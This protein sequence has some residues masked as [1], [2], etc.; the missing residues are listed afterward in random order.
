MHQR[1]QKLAIATVLAS[2]MAV[3]YWAWS[4]QAPTVATGKRDASLAVATPPGAIGATDAMA[5]ATT[6]AVVASAGDEKPVRRLSTDARR[7]GELGTAYAGRRDALVAYQAF[8]TRARLS[9]PQSEAMLAILLDAQLQ[10]DE[11]RKA[12]RERLTDPAYDEEKE[13]KDRV[14]SGMTKAIFDDVMGRARQVLTDEQLA[15]F[16][17]EFDA[18][19]IVAAATSLVEPAPVP[20]AG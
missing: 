14:P 7:P 19:I 20:Q 16:A 2:S 4:R 17:D 9:P 18:W 1:L 5:P 15:I 8:L 11:F 6:A 13:F 12:R 10:Y 3:A